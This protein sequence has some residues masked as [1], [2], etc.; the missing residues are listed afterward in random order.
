MTLAGTI[1]NYLQANWGAAM[2]PAVSEIIWHESWFDAKRGMGPEAQITVTDFVRPVGQMFTGGGGGSLFS[3]TY[4]RFL[5]NC[6][7]REPRGYLG[8]L[9]MGSINAMRDE[10]LRVVQEGWRA[11]FSGFGRICIPRDEGVPLHEVDVTPRLM[12]YEITLMGTRDL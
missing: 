10:V 5:V 3:R 7:F 4:P 1:L 12:R 9:N 11:I 6:W 8:T 2:S